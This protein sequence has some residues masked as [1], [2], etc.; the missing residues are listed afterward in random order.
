MPVALIV[1]AGTGLSASLA[2][3]FAKEGFQVAVASRHK[4]KISNLGF[5]VQCDATDLKQLDEA[6]EA[7]EHK[8]GT[9]DLVVYNA[10]YRTRG[11]FVELKP[12]E[13]KKTLES[14]AFGG[15][16]VAQA[17]VKRMLHRGSGAIFFT[18]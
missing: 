5:A 11:P 16:L 2:R 14:S 6:F 13:V 4:D 12:E 18:G 10:G 7:V 8:F 9:P 15:F 3:L 1:G 17:A